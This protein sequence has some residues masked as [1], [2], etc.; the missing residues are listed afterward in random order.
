MITL[1]EIESIVSVEHTNVYRISLKSTTWILLAIIIIMSA[2]FSILQLPPTFGSFNI[3]MYFHS[4]GIGIAAL[5][6]CLVI[7]IFELDKHEPA[8]DFPIHY[9][10]LI[11]E[12]LAAISALFYLVPGLNTTLPDVAVAILIVAFVLIA[13]VGGALLIEMFELPRKLNGTFNPKGNYIALMIPL[14]KN[15]WG[16][17]KKMK[18]TYWLTL[19]A[20]ASAFLAGMIGF[21][22]LWVL[23]FGASFFTPY[24][25]MLGIGASDFLDATLDPHSHMMGLALMAGVVGIVAQQFHALELK[26]WKKTVVRI[27][28]WVSFFGVIAMS[29]VLFYAAAAN[30][31]PPNLFT[32][33][34]ANGIASDDLSMSIIGFGALIA[35]VPLFLTKLGKTETD[36]WTDPVRFG[37]LFTWVCALFL[38]IVEGFYIELNEDTFASSLL[39]NDNVY[40]AIQPLFGIFLLTAT[41]IFLLAADY[42]QVQETFRMIIG[43]LAIV[44]LILS[45]LGASYWIFF[46]PTTGGIGSIV[47]YLGL[48]IIGLSGIA[49]IVFIISVKATSMKR[50][51]VKDSPDEKLEKVTAA[52]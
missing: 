31:G 45:T 40:S 14:S 13:D 39:S 12:I 41:S 38:N 33:G 42:Y 8:I 29:T 26:D 44:G 46:N 6:S 24:I 15:D 11:A 34:Q 2:L 25:N 27:G 35:L 1:V 16:S 37:V 19:F 3:D 52:D 5:A 28:L 10:A 51:I 9:R 50:T 4:I 49:T 47:Y 7:S 36:S 30:W 18:V 48:L 22:N 20:I 21:V 23:I 43:W 17:Y 32:S